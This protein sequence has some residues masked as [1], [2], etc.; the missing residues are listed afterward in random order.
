MDRDHVGMVRRLELYAVIVTDGVAPEYPP[1]LYDSLQRATLEAERWAWILSGTGWLDVERPFEGKWVV[2]DRDV[3]L[4]PVQTE[5]P[6]TSDVW[7]GQFWQKDGKPD[8]EA[9]ILGSRQDAISWVMEGPVGTDPII[10]T[11]EKPWFVSATYRLGGEE[12]FA[13]ASLAKHIAA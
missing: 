10:E 9:L 11:I 7:I 3:R 2:A 8:P 6:T 12:A 13:I 5:A 1:E 4:V